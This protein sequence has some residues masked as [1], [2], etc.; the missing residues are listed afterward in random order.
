MIATGDIA[1][2]MKRQHWFPRRFDLDRYPDQSAP[3]KHAGGA[4]RSN[5]AKPAAP[6]RIC[7]NPSRWNDVHKQ[8]VNYAE[9]HSCRPSR[10]PAPLILAGW[11]YSN[12][13]EKMHRWKETVDWASA[14]GCAEI[15]K[16]VSDQ[17]LYKV[18]EPTTYSIGPM[19]GPCYRQWDTEAKV[20]PPEEE[21]AKHFEYL[22]AHWVDVAGLDLSMVTR[23]V[24]FT[25]KKARRLLVQAEGEAIPP[26]GGW[27]DRS[28][29]EAKRRTFTRFR[30]AVNKAIAPHEV[31]HIDFVTDE[32]QAR[33]S[34]PI[35]SAG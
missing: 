35:T 9:A 31:D 6:Q 23:P 21:L 13:T 16:A 30:S 8:L 12:D 32:E 34:P 18:E 7:P 19:G 26:W 5:K 14:N 11:A 24:A 29:E 28:T 22:S 27:F 10:P 2:H 33:A 15:V 20:R 17:D 25:G 1:E 4:V 3:V